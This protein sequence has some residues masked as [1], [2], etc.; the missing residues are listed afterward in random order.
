MSDVTTELHAGNEAVYDVPTKTAENTPTGDAAK[1][2]PQPPAVS[3][4]QD[5]RN[6]QMLLVSGIF[7]GNVAPQIVQG[8]KL[9]DDMAA[10]IEKEAGYVAKP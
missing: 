3:P 5:L 6:L 10:K 4:A 9:L 8:Y 2:K 1:G 7:P